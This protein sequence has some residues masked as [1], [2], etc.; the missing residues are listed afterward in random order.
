M[1]N[2]VFDDS[3]DVSFVVSELFRHVH[4]LASPIKKRQLVLS[5]SSFPLLHLLFWDSLSVLVLLA[6]TKD[7]IS[8]LQK[9]QLWRER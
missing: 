8:K 4:V 3:F 1:T 7:P 5:F 6:S 9:Y 2:I